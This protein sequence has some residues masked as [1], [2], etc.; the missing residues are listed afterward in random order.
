MR[1]IEWNDNFTT[2]VHECDIQH[3]KIINVFNAIYDA[4]RLNVDKRTLKDVFNLNRIVQENLKNISKFFREKLEQ[5]GEQ[6]REEYNIQIPKIDLSAIEE[7][8][9]KEVI[10]KKITKEVVESV[11]ENWNF[12]KPWKWLKSGRTKRIIVGERE[13]LNEKA[14]FKS[15]KNNLI[16]S[17]VEVIETLRDQF[18]KAFEFYKKR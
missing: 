8:C 15:L 10:R 9:R 18:Y 16:E 14:Y 17:F 1:F 3:K 2:G 11:T 4:I 7:R 13:V 12:L 6:Y 5:I